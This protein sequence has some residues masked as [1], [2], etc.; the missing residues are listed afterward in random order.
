MGVSAHLRKYKQISMVAMQERKVK[1]D[2]TGE[3]KK[4]RKL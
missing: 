4:G 3:P 2:E 1:G